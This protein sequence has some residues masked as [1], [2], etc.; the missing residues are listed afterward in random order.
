MNT[1][2][3]QNI[4]TL[5]SLNDNDKILFIDYNLTITDDLPS[6]YNIIQLE[7]G[8]YFTFQESLNSSVSNRTLI[9][10]INIS[11]DKLYDNKFFLNK[12]ESNERLSKLMDDLCVKIDIITEQYNKNNY[13]NNVLEELFNRSIVYCKSVVKYHQI[14]TMVESESESESECNSDNDDDFVK[15]EDLKQ[16]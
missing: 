13:C 14:T 2:A 16:E 12:L 8:I 6:D 11:I 10:D 1:F 9:N 4:N 7:Y 3:S 15:E 5:T